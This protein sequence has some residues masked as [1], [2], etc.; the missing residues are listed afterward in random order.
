MTDDHVAGDV[1][2][3]FV[4]FLFGTVLAGLV[5]TAFTYKSWREQ[6]RLDFA[7]ERLADATK[8]FDNA[9]QLISER[10]FRSYEVQKHIGDDA[11]TFA[12]HRDKLDSAIENWNLAYADMLQRIQF[13]LEVDDDG[14]MRPYRDVH[15][16]DFYQRL[17]CAKALDDHNR[18][19][20]ADWSSPSWLF[21]ALHYCFIY[22][23][24][25]S[26]SDALR[27][28]LP[29]PERDA[30]VKK[31]NDEIDNLDAH[32]GRVRVAGKKA[33]ERMRHSVETH[34]FWEFLKSW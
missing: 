9:S 5:T 10:L 25:G 26:R 32:A 11:V 20:Q 19:A 15:T 6:T 14:K 29:S 3:K 34:S 2:G 24:V 18:P 23:E 33:I 30:E 17:D 8:T 12:K 13:A 31:L 21:A 1:S 27:K 4:N 7:K 16:T 28:E 22:T